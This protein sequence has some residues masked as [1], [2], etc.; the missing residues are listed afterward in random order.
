[1]LEISDEEDAKLSEKARM[2]KCWN[3]K[4][5]VI[6]TI[7]LFSI[8]AVIFGAVITKYGYDKMSE[9]SLDIKE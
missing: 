5:L 1:M 7:C 8:F 9:N 3:C 6:S 4:Q 2:A